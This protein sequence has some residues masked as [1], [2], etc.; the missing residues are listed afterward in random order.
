MKDSATSSRSQARVRIQPARP[1]IMGRR[2]VVTSGHY[3]ATAAGMRAVAL[4]GNA[5][6]AGVAAGLA[7][8]VLKPQDN[9]IGGEVPILIHDPRSGNVTAIAGQGTAPARATIEYFRAAG[10]SLIPGNGLLAAMVPGA[11]DAWVTALSLHG[12][13]SLRQ[14]IEPALELAADGFA[15]YAGLRNAILRHE[16]KFRAEWPTSA[17]VFLPGGVVPAI[18]DRFRQPDW[19]A[20]LSQ[21]VE[22]EDA[23]LAAGLSRQEGLRAARDVFYKGPIARAIARFAAETE[24]HDHSG[25]ANR[26]LIAYD[27]LANY[28]THLEEPV[29]ID[30]HGLRVY[31][32]GPWSQ[33]PVFLQ[34]LRLLEGY[35][36]PALGHNSAEY[37]HLVTEA[38]KLAFADRDRYYGDPRF[39]S[40][41]MD[42]LLSHD[43]AAGR[44]ALIHTAAASVAI[45]PGEIDTTGAGPVPDGGAHRRDTTHLDA[46][47]ADGLMLSATPSGGWMPSSP[48]VAGLGFPLGTRGQMFWLDPDHPNS[49]APGKRPRTTLTPTL[50]TRSGSPY[51]VFGTPGGDQQD[52]W[53]LQFFLNLVDF[54]MDLQEAIDAPTFH[55]DHFPASFYPRDTA[56]GSLSIEGRVDQETRAALARLGH[57]ITE[58]GDW[59]HGQVCAVR[60]DAESGRLEGAASPRGQVAYAMG[61]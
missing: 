13:L 45:R 12:T 22:A 39:A 6:D 40:V 60:F 1:V 19:A 38:A 37:I 59:A 46:I 29:S 43:Y 28:Q 4:G 55:T 61:Y 33:G 15:M 18:G 32:C 2:C 21:T 5:V 3:L 58:A 53:T 16:A 9:G 52:Q 14:V 26:G 41:P 11:F 57:R 35:D 56:L 44:R 27:D 50:V 20:A 24:V 51:L 8:A 42:R 49:L 17:A 34:Q 10:I 30:Y 36:L 23:A 47:D 25:R 7:L 31:K 54:G 48:V